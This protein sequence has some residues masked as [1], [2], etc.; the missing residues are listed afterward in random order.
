MTDP[1]YT[2]IC[3]VVDRSGS[4]TEILSDAQGAINAFLSDQRKATDG[5]RTVRVAQFDGL[6]DVV[7]PSLP[8]AQVPEY[9]IIPRGMTAL[10]DAFGR[11]LTEFG[12]EL[13]SMPEDER[14]ANVIFALMTDGLEN[15]SKEWTAERV[16]ELVK[17]QQSV[18]GWHVLYL[19]ANQDALQVGEKLGVARGSALTYEASSV[20]VAAAASSMSS[21]VSRAVS[22]LSVSDAAFTEAERK[23]ADPVPHKL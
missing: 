1:N 13:A 17:R 6:Y 18:Y 5:K 21:Y 10:W 22:G 15:V 16:R 20:G 4:I 11:G 12:E 3:L 23:A 14:P 8:A 9:T 7:H 2:A 19:G